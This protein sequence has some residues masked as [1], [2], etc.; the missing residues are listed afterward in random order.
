M[1]SGV[2]RFVPACEGKAMF[3]PLNQSISGCNVTGTLIYGV[4]VGFAE[5][6]HSSRDEK[7]PGVGFWAGPHSC[8]FIT[9]SLE[10]ERVEV[11]PVRCPC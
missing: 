2:K 6:V 11:Q 8:N 5:T 3:S 7:E 9:R 10:A 1:K 4:Y